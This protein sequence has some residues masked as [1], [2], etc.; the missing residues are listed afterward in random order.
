MIRKF[1]FRYGSDT[2]KQRAAIRYI[3]RIIVTFTR[4]SIVCDS[5]VR[6]YGS[7]AT[8]VV[9][10]NRWGG[11]TPLLPPSRTIAYIELYGIIWLYPKAI[12]WL[13]THY[14]LLNIR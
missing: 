2:V 5:S 6:Q 11:P 4:L 12:K 7:K 3:S 14:H 13:T 9:W 8:A 10:S 1:H